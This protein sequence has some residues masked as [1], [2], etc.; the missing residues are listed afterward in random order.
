MKFR[1]RKIFLGLCVF[2]FLISLFFVFTNPGLAQMPDMPDSDI[3]DTN[4][5]LFELVEKII[6]GVLGF[7]GVIAVVI[8]LYGGFLWMTAAGDGN[9]VDKAKKTLR[10]GTIGLVIVLTAWAIVRFIFGLFGLDGG[11]CDPCVYGTDTTQVCWPVCGAGETSYSGTKTCGSDNCW[12][13][14]TGYCDP[15]GPP[16]PPAYGEFTLRWKYPSDGETGVSRCSL[17]QASFNHKIVDSNDNKDRVT[18]YECADENCVFADMTEFTDGQ[19]IIDTD[20]KTYTFYP[21]IDYNQNTWY[22]VIINGDFEDTS[23]ENLGSN[24]EWKFK[25]GSATDDTAPTVS[26]KYPTGIDVCISS[27]IQAEFSEPMDARTLNTDNFYL[28]SSDTSAIIPNFSAYTPSNILVTYQPDS[29]YSVFTEYTSEVLG[30][31]TDRS[32]WDRTYVDQGV[33]DVCGNPLAPPS[34][35]WDFKT[36]DNADCRPEITSITPNA[37]HSNTVTI[38]GYYFTLGGNVVFNHNVYDSADTCFD[39]GSAGYYDPNQSCG[40]GANWWEPEEITL[41]LPAGGGNSNGPVNGPLEVKITDT[42]TYGGVSFNGLNDISDDDLIVESPHI[43]VVSGYNGTTSVNNGSGARGG[44]GQIITIMGRNFGSSGNVKFINTDTGVV[45]NS[46]ALP[47]ACSGT[48]WSDNQVAA[49]VPSGFN[50]NDDLKIQLDTDDISGSPQKYSNLMSFKFT[51]EVGPGICG[52]S[53][54]CAGGSSGGSSGDNYDFETDR[55]GGAGQIRGMAFGTLAEKLFFGS[56]ELNSILSGSPDPSNEDSFGMYGWGDQQIDSYIPFDLAFG[57]NP[58]K[59]VDSSGINSNAWA[60]RVPCDFK[61]CDNNEATQTC[62]P[63]DSKCSSSEYCDLNTCECKEAFRVIAQRPDCSSAC[64]NTEIEV[65]FSEEVDG[66]TLARNIE[67]VPNFTFSSS[68]T[69]DSV[70]EKSLL[71]LTPNRALSTSTSY[72]VIL[73]EGITS[74]GGKPLAKLN[75]DTDGDSVNDSYSW[76]FTTK[77]D[78]TF[79]IATSADIN[80]PGALEVNATGGYNSRLGTSGNCGAPI[81]G[82]YSYFWSEIGRPLLSSIDTPSSSA[83]DV[84]ADGTPGTA[85][86][87][88]AVTGDASLNTD[89]DITITDGS[90]PPPGTGFRVI[91]N[92][93]TCDYAC[94]NTA[95]RVEFSEPLDSGAFDIS[96]VSVDNGASFDALRTQIAG[97]FLTLYFDTSLNGGAT[98]NIT[99]DSNIESASGETLGG[100]FIW[101]F[102]TANTADLC[103]PDNIDIYSPSTDPVE[104]VSGRSKIFSTSAGSSANCPNTPI[105]LSG[106]GASYTWDSD[107]ISV[108]TAT[109]DV[110]DNSKAEVEAVGSDGETTSVEVE[111]SVGG[112][113]VAS[114]DKDVKIVSGGGVGDP[115]RDAITAPGCSPNRNCNVNLTCDPGSCTCQPMLEDLEITSASAPEFCTNG[116]VEVTFNEVV[117]GPACSLLSLNPTSWTVNT[118]TCSDYRMFVS[119]TSSF[120]PGNNYSLEISE[121]GSLV[122]PAGYNPINFTLDPGADKCNLYRVEVTPEEF[123]FNRRDQLKKFQSQ[124]YSRYDSP[125]VF[126]NRANAA[127]W[128]LSGTGT[129][130]E[131]DGTNVFN[132]VNSTVKVKTDDNNPVNLDGLLQVSVVDIDDDGDMITEVDDAEVSINLCERR[133]KFDPNGAAG[134]DYHYKDDFVNFELSY[135]L[136]NNPRYPETLEVTTGQD[137]PD[138]DF[139]SNKHLLFKDKNGEAKGLIGMLVFENQNYQD[140]NRWFANKFDEFYSGGTEEIN[141]YPAIRVG[142]S[143]YVAATNID[144]PN[145]YINIYLLTHDDNADPEMIELYDE[146]LEN[147]KFNTNLTL[148]QE[149][150]DQL[151]RDAQRIMDLAY[152]RTLL[153]NYREQE[154][155]YPLLTM[156]DYYEAGVTEGAMMPGEVTSLWPAW[157]TLF[158]RELSKANRGVDLPKDP[159]NELGMPGCTAPTDCTQDSD[160]SGCTGN[161]GG[162]NYTARCHEGKCVKLDPAFSEET[163]WHNFDRNYACPD[164]SYFYLYQVDGSP[165]DADY[166]ENYNLLGNMEYSSS[167]WNSFDSGTFDPGCINW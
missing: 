103:E 115:C 33:R 120:T 141:G 165:T 48:A 151:A 122:P 82:N 154:G 9:Q 49:V 42:T 162:E 167:G 60:F 54:T 125:I 114:D 135:C 6:N 31:S 128:H 61:P 166:G 47:S 10:N 74:L 79:C 26:R 84:T 105:D 145:N 30:S 8:M 119:S 149:E 64:V 75:Y 23:G 142:R 127:V 112:S 140:V 94:L 88:L 91:E 15:S 25:T 164:E 19:E 71:T 99:L 134:D 126:N 67:V 21:N 37:K 163:G 55:D 130:L 87:D 157:E 76:T 123:E 59:V 72:R 14:C 50:L 156:D 106:L 18:V 111:L 12:G 86:L 118:K 29:H 73:K 66:A 131:F 5:N 3:V 160:C 116:M 107:D 52:T 62:E 102:T 136:D 16:P 68:Y 139:M 78:S 152:I 108:A 39:G 28:S 65:E 44:D 43:D 96:Q 153:E 97:N 81:W 129:S 121:S 147:I 80:G 159:L 90:G 53:F 58:L 144:A 98:Y 2:L 56:K 45:K 93:P 137:L 100:D 46:A 132:N 161:Y 57:S 24:V 109:A 89:K 11:G 27:V 138:S 117:E 20:G 32:S 51:D 148:T 7:L 104:I 41:K 110:S 63:T 155:T 22:K 70:T 35:D 143:T 4:L 92:Y 83:T 124:G 13:N 101:D 158:R 133:G 1:G 17:I 85:T 95:V 36:S 150:K 34:H 77:N 69:Y 113:S 40:V 38:E 146:L